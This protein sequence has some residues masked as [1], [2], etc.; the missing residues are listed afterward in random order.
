[1]NRKPTCM[2]KCMLGTMRTLVAGGVEVRVE[3]EPNQAVD[4]FVCVVWCGNTYIES[5]GSTGV[6]GGSRAARRRAT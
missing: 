4:L 3:D 1:M 5:V 6:A 2:H